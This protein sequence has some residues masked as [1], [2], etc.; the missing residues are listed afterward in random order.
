MS[1]DKKEK[2]CT[3]EELSSLKQLVMDLNTSKLKLA[4]YALEMENVKSVINVIRQKMSTKEKELIEKYGD[5]AKINLETG[6]ITK[7]NPTPK[8][9]MVK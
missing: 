5:D 8:L 6:A 2:Y 4:D 3:E 9:E 1:K 7:K